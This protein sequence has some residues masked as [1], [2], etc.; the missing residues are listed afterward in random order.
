MSEFQGPGYIA[1]PAC[2]RAAST[3]S[4][5]LDVLFYKAAVQSPPARE[6][7]TTRF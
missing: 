1:S 5:T 4:N 2:S 3:G 7:A 6:A